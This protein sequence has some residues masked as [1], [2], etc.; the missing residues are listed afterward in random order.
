MY[1]T[2]SS[3]EKALNKKTHILSTKYSGSVGCS[4]P[5]PKS[6]S[7]LKCYGENPCEERGHKHKCKRLLYVDDIKSNRYMKAALMFTFTI[8]KDNPDGYIDAE[9]PQ[10]KIL[11]EQKL[12]DAKFLVSARI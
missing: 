11:I 3:V 7:L 5:K 1:Y 10:L 8:S 2:A 6:I 12:I 4:K 9:N